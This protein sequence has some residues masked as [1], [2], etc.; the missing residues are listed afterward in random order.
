MG[1]CSSCKSATPSLTSQRKRSSS[2]GTVVD[3]DT[4][5]TAKAT[6]A[7]EKIRKKDR[8]RRASE[9]GGGHNLDKTHHIHKQG[10]LDHEARTSSTASR[11]MQ[12]MIHTE[13]SN[14]I[15]IHD[16]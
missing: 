15:S 12:K 5:V 13:S 8:V 10:D 14:G 3:G 16:L 1:L 11:T 4:I 9:A 6:S 2:K 7:N